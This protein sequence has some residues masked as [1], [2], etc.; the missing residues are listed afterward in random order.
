MR[1]VPAQTSGMVDR[2]SSIVNTR[3][4]AVAVTACALAIAVGG[5]GSSSSK[6]SSSSSGGGTSAKTASK[7]PITVLSI[8]DTSGPTKIIGQTHYEGLEAAAAYYNS[9]GG[10]GGHHVVIHHVNDNGV[11][12]SAV[13]GLIQQLSSGSAPTMI[14]AGAEAGDSAALIPVIAKRSL[15]AMALN[16]GTHQCQTNASVTC[17]NEFT[18]AAPSQDQ[19]VTVANWLKQKGIKKVGILVE[20]IDFAQTETPSFV[21]ALNQAGIAHTAVKFPSTSIDVTPELQQLKASGAQAVYVEALAAPAGEAF[22]ARA[23]LSWNVPLV[24]DIASASLDL[25]KLA[26]VADDKNAYEDIF[27]EQSPK[28]RSPGIPTLLKYSK[29][30]GNITVVPLDVA[31]TGWDE[32]V[33]LNAAV[34]EAGG[35]LKVKDLD[36]AMLKLPPTDPNRTF[37]LKLGWTAKDHENV[38]ATPKDFVVV[39]VGAVVNGQVQAP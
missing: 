28:D 30:F 10:I 11:A 12:T 16:D 31:S 38:R 7:A 39:P 21:T 20:A 13:S 9:H 25:T 35:S 5:C 15:F 1:P 34:K 18:L 29:P 19:Q 24:F 26:P 8:G 36:A 23:T 27:D 14:D 4:V 22:K 2:E 32:L 33:A 17:P 3:S 6:G 37:S